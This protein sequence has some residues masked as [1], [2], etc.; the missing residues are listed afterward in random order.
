MSAVRERPRG[1]CRYVRILIKRAM[2]KIRS[3]D[4]LYALLA[5]DIPTGRE[6]ERFLETRDRLH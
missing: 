3:L 6:R 4:Q 2:K 5:E 1:Y